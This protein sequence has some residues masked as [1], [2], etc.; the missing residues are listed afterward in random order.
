MPDNHLA[1]GIVSLRPFVPAKDF[2]TSKRFYIDLGFEVA[3]LGDKLAHVG[4]GTFAFLLQDYFIQEWADNFVMHMLVTNLDQ[5]WTTVSRL[6]LESRYRVR[7]PLPPKME[8]WGLRV[9][10]IFDPSGILWHLAEEAT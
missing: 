4:I 6:N 2:Q 9:A 8:P 1:A 10:Y 5:W 3:S 7:A